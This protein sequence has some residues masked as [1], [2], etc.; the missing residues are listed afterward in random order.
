[1]LP[2]FLYH[3]SAISSNLSRKADKILKQRFEEIVLP[4]QLY[5]APPTGFND[6]FDCH[7]IPELTEQ[8]VTELTQ[9]NFLARFPLLKF[10]KLLHHITQNYQQQ[11]LAEGNL[12][13][14]GERLRKYIRENYGIV[15]F[16][17][18]KDSIPMFAYY[19]GGH[20]GFCLEF[21]VK[22]SPPEHFF[23]R[24]RRITYATEFPRLVF[25]HPTHKEIV[26][27]ILATKCQVWEHE[28]EWRLIKTPDELNNNR[29]VQFPAQILTGVILG[30]TIT[31]QSRNF[32]KKL[33]RQR[34][35][36]IKLI[37][38]KPAVGQYAIDLTTQI[39]Y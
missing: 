22:H 21:T 14:A 34:K 26:D 17:E 28:K 20:S 6:P 3:Y 23:E 38:A 36:P 13:S 10:Q 7:Y 31:E 12:Q 18:L 8:C 24:A 27:I 35:I 9:N 16:S 39:A 4:G 19:A 37:Q 15:C 2:P 5:F 1:M 30:C 29:Q 11:L 32:I 25:E 33:L